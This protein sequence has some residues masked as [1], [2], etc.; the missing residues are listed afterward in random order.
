MLVFLGLM[1]VET[2]FIGVEFQ[3]VFLIMFVDVYLFVDYLLLLLISSRKAA[4]PMAQ[5]D[6]VSR[7][8]QEAEPQGP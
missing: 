7:Q 6:K 4:A 5:L 2:V 8:D 3:C 1:F